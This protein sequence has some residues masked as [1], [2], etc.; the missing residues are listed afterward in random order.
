MNLEPSQI[1]H[2]LAVKQR[3]QPVTPTTDVVQVT[4]EILALHATSPVGP[5]LSLWARL[6][7]FTPRMLEEALYEQRELVKVLCMRDTL[8]VIPS[9]ELP[10]F[11]QAYAEGRTPTTLKTGQTLLA[12]GGLCQ[13]DEAKERLDEL[14]R[15]VLAA[16]ASQGP[17]TVAQIS[18]SIPALKTKIQHSAGKSYAG[19][20]SLGSRLVPGMC[21]LGSL[22]RSRPRGT[23]RSNLYEYAPMSAWLPDVDLEITT[24][25][26]ART[27]LVRRYLSTFGPAT[28]EDIQWW[29]GFS[30]GEIEE[31]LGS[32]RPRLVHVSIPGFRDEHLML[33]ED[34]QQL[35]SLKNQKGSF[36]F[37]LPG[38]DPYIMA[39]RHRGR[40][41]ELEHH[42]KVFDR[43]GNAMPT[44][45]A[46]GRVVGAWGQRKDG[47]IVYRT[48]KPINDLEEI[49][50]EEKREE[51]VDFLDG[52]R[53]PQPSHTPFTRALVSEEGGK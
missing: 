28:I 43:A 29:S 5:Y 17:S 3:L 51:L 9:E 4:Q 40:F 30:K 13:P 8:H 19:E 24:P 39:Y 16:L 32:L 41:L 23:W 1:N 33:A 12:L 36:A 37:F 7:G 14:H 11:F 52:E 46:N 35:H 18:K 21:A 42:A 50:L 53:L 48:F 2:Y 20:F 22:V 25:E 6:P 49:K 15:Q 44:I 45:W 26:E 31:S 47:S 38:L 34:A 27:W 10:F